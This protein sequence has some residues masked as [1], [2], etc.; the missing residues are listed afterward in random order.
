MLSG[1]QL[2]PSERM[3]RLDQ[4]PRHQIVLLYLALSIRRQTNSPHH[5]PPHQY[6]LK[7]QYQPS[8]P[9]PCQQQPST[10]NQTM[11]L[12]LSIFRLF[13]HDSPCTCNTISR[14]D[15][16]ASPSL[17]TR[18]TPA[19]SLIPAFGAHIWRVLSCPASRTTACNESVELGSSESNMTLLLGPFLGAEL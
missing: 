5:L 10:T 17:P 14:L 9:R 16:Q 19:K 12:Q 18:A 7:P 11:G 13:K 2:C 8:C 4:L 15:K 6:S 1:Q 3:I